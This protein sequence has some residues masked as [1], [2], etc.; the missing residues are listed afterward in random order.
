MSGVDKLYRNDG[1]IFV[2][3][4]AVVGTNDTRQSNSTSWGDLNNDGFLDLY[5]SNNG[6]ENRLYKSNAASTNRWVIF[7]LRGTVSVRSAIGAR[8]RVRT[9]SISQIREVQGGS[10]HNGQNSLPVEFGLG[11]AITIDSLVIRWPSGIVQ[12][13][14]NINSNQIID[15]VEGEPIGIITSNNKLPERFELM[16]NYPNPFNPGTVISFQL[17]VFSYVRLIMYDM[18]GREIATL[19]DGVSKAGS[20]SLEWDGS[21]YE[22]GV[23]FYRMEINGKIADTKKMVLIK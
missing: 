14:A 19:L 13:A 11:T 10:G 6:T 23:Y 18:L 1:S 22:S 7:R 9:G 12:T 5:L 15:V 20:H 8:V 3:V 2:D 21:E 17:P 4:A 16:Q